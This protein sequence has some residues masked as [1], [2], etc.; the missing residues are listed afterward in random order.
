MSHRRLF[1][2]TVTC[3]L[4]AAFTPLASA[5]DRVAPR[6]PDVT[7]LMRVALAKVTHT[8]GYSRA[9]LRAAS[10]TTAD[11]GNT[12]LAQDITNWT[13]T[14]DNGLTPGATHASATLTFSAGGWGKV[15]AG[16]GL[17]IGAG[18]IRPLPVMTLAHA[19]QI[20]NRAGVTAAF[21][22]VQLV[23]VPGPGFNQ[24]RYTFLTTDGAATVGARNGRVVLPS[25]VFTI[26]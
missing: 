22:L 17:G 16:G 15:T 5:A 9:V 8:P 10:G 1:V 3:A 21:N 20:L 6:T 25:L 2:L 24:P 12:T 19:V 14:F 4:L 13:F 11:S 7:F 23:Y 26:N 18:D